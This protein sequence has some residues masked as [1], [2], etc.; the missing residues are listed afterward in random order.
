MIGLNLLLNNR[1]GEKIENTAEE[2]SFPT[3]VDS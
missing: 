1:Y 2:L 3:D